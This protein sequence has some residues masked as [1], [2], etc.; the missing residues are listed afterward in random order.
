MK[1]PSKMCLWKNIVFERGPVRNVSPK[2]K[3][4]RIFF[5]YFAKIWETAKKEFPSVQNS[6]IY[7]KV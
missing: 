6:E 2:S 4:A 1:K 5:P 7:D 3:N